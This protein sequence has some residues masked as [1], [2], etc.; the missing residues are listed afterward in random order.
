LDGGF[1]VDYFPLCSTCSV[2][3]Q[4]RIFH[5]LRVKNKKKGTP[6]FCD[7]VMIIQETTKLKVIIE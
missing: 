3:G 2:E 6:S 7:L 1:M 5:F 4:T